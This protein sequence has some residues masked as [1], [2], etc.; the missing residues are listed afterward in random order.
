MDEIN[1]NIA[2][3][4]KTQ[5]PSFYAEEG[6][7]F[8]EFMAAYYE[9][10][11]SNEDMSLY[12]SKRMLEYA[13]I[14]DTIDA[15][16][17]HFK[18][19]YLDTFPYILSTDVRFAV[20]HILDLYRS[21][22][23]ERGLKLFMRLLFNE[24]VEIYYPA[25]DILKPS[26]SLWRI[27][28]YV[29]VSRSP[30]NVEFVNQEITGV[31]SGA[32][33]FVE[34][35]ITKRI[36]GKFIDVFYLSN[37]RNNFE[38]DEI[39]TYDGIIE[40]SP[41]IIGSL[42]RIEVIN[43]G[44]D[45]A[46]G[47]IFNVISENGQQGKAKVVSISEDI[48]SVNFSILDGGSGYTGDGNTVV[49]VSNT[50][51]SVNNANLD[52][53]MYETVKQPLQKLTPD[54]SSAF[55]ND[56]AVDSR[57]EGR[58]AN[59]AIVVEGTVV[60]VATNHIV[61][62]PDQGESFFPVYEISGNSSLSNFANGEVVSSGARVILDLNSVSGD[63]TNGELVIQLVEQTFLGGT[64]AEFVYVT[65][66][67]TGYVEDYDNLT[68]RLTLN[69]VFGTFDILETIYTE[70]GGAN[71]IVSVANTTANAA[72][73]IITNI[74]SNTATLTVTS[75]SFANT[76]LIKGLATNQQSF[77]DQIN[78][79][80]ALTVRLANTI[81]EANLSTVDDVSV[82]GI[83]VGQSETNVGLYGSNGFFSTITQDLYI[84][85]DRNSDL[86][87]NNPDLTFVV[88]AKSQG[89]G[90]N[91]AIDPNGLERTQNVEINTDVIGGTNITN[92]LYKNLK[93]KGLG[94]INELTINDGGTGYTTNSAIT[95][96]AGGVDGADPFI[97]A[98][99]TITS[100][101]ANGTITGVSLT[102]Q[103]L[104]YDTEPTITIA[105]GAGANL[106]ITM[107]YGYGFPKYPIGGLDTTI[108]DC[109]DFKT[110]EIGTV[111][112]ITRINPGSGYDT[113]PYV[114]VYNPYIAG[115]DKREVK[116]FLTDIIGSFGEGDIIQQELA[117][118][119]VAVGTV[120]AFDKDAGAITLKMNSFNEE[121][122]VNGSIS[123]T[124]TSSSGTITYIEEVVASEEM[125]DNLEMN[126]RV[127]IAPDVALTLEVIDSGYGY[128][129]DTTVTL[130]RDGHPFEITG[131][132]KV[133]KQGTGPGYWDSES[134][135]LNSNKRIRDNLYYQ[136]YS[137]DVRSGNSLNKYRDILRKTM[138][139]AGTELFGSVVKETKVNLIVSTNCTITVANT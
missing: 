56:V 138:H 88:T 83:V 75:G 117:P 65:N 6:E 20:K 115:F 108:A 32:K 34:S 16:L 22:G 84:T 44:R 49:Y 71:G 107:E 50:I 74:T 57:V 112:S 98:D 102:N 114:R 62:Q 128:L 139:V 26:D 38:Y 106:G 87:L 25:K 10:M 29:E 43:G 63:F 86:F 40:G 81:V 30:R 68:S 27:P 54:F 36:D 41:K 2:Q 39:V 118:A 131:T 59:A 92:F 37:I 60:S 46:I 103:G 42:S 121:F 116:L 137:Y 11:E 133:E 94:R 120:R 99:A 95:F 80:G 89:S 105:D 77:I 124:T 28:R 45:N 101:D 104:G 53:R 24:N 123:V 90:A 73:G 70:D 19:K 17:I 136:E 48:G 91:F 14:D 58:D 67:A 130:L 35:L 129:N 23:T 82:S 18:N 135:H 5:F 61:V 97:I 66:Y 15:F 72:L 7:V 134:S 132:A 78:N 8:Q 64:N 69:R 110:F 3:Y 93:I 85:T 33:A 111:R 21:K 119:V 109:L 47:D 79:N 125:G 31:V 51:L 100:V 127:Q 12:R 52:F 76:D 55:F 96:V 113:N 126:R 1:K 122:T 9:F 13:D 4:V